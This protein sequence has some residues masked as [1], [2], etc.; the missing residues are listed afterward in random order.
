MSGL[1]E[2]KFKFWLNNINYNYIGNKYDNNNEETEIN[3]KMLSYNKDIIV[4]LSELVISDELV[5]KCKNI[6]ILNT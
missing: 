5:N 2:D 3:D 6:D 1:Y 4:K